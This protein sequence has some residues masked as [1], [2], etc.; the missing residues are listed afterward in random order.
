[1]KRIYK[2]YHTMENHEYREVDGE[3][4]VQIER[5]ITRLEENNTKREIMQ[6]NRDRN[7]RNRKGKS[8]KD[9]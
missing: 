1:M 5:F 9:G 2:S 6:K 3:Y 4:L 8:R 7:D